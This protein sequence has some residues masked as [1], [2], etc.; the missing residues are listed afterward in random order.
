MADSRKEEINKCIACSYD[1]E[2]AFLYIRREK[3]TR[4]LGDCK[5]SGRFSDKKIKFIVLIIQIL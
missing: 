5:Q 4:N 3:G 2:Q 1:Y